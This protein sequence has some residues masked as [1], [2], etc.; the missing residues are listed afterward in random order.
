MIIV[1]LFLQFKKSA[2]KKQNKKIIDMNIKNIE[3]K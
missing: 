3:E 2:S 1:I